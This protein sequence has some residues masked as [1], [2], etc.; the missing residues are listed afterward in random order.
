ME[1]VALV[2]SV[3][4]TLGLGLTLL[5]GRTF[6]PAYLNEKG[7]NLASKDDLAHLTD[8]V[9][10]VKASY[11]ADL[12]R[13]KASHSTDLERIKAT[14]LSEAQVT[15]RRRQMYDAICKSLRVFL[16][17]SAPSKEDKDNFIHSYSLAYLWASDSVV[18]HLNKFVASQVI[19]ATNNALLSQDQ[20]RE[21]YANLMDAMRKDVG[22]P[23][24]KIRI[25]DHQFVSFSDF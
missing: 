4:S 16:S 1:I 18:E 10:K 22:Y 25:K 14:L 24:T 6:L 11:V 8:L 17:G 23:D 2:L 19:F 21:Y 7:K 20:L 9:E 15:E 12:E 5:L 3:V 13:L